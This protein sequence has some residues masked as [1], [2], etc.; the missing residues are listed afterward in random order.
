[1]GTETYG[2]LITD[3]YKVKKGRGQSSQPRKIAMY[4]AQ[5]LGGHRLTDIARA[6]GLSH[7]GGVSYAIYRLKTEMEE[8]KRLSRTINLIIN[9]LDP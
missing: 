9:G 7:Y 1:M 8:D 6:F 2:V 3:I 5:H 4:L